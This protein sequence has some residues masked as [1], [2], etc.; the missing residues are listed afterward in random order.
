MRLYQIEVI[1][2]FLVPIDSS[3]EPKSGHWPILGTQACSLCLNT[4]TAL[5]LIKCSIIHHGIGILNP[6]E[7]GIP[8]LKGYIWILNRRHRVVV[9]GFNISFF[10]A[11]FGLFASDP[12][13]DG[14][15]KNSDVVENLVF[16]SS[17]A[18]VDH[19]ASPINASCVRHSRDRL[20]V[21]W[22]LLDWSSLNRCLVHNL[23]PALFFL[24]Y[25]FLTCKGGLELDPA[26]LMAQAIIDPQVA[27]GLTALCGLE[28]LGCASKHKK[29][30]THIWRH[31]VCVSLLEF[32]N[33]DILV[34]MAPS[35]VIELKCPQISHWLVSISGKKPKFAHG[36]AAAQLG[37][38]RCN[39]STFVFV[40]LD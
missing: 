25:R 40:R 33:H 10:F 1:H 2:W 29:V 4:G 8:R 39:F 12:F 21:V 23:F 19:K 20:I 13:S 34:D 27:Q 31:C 15:V 3:K 37:S 35:L 18:A 26:L 16:L 32:C 24:L 22:Y 36:K 14:N 38:C 17:V 7:P 6:H 9:P 30:A 11:S 28:E 5:S